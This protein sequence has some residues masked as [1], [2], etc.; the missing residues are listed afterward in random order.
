MLLSSDARADAV[1]DSD[2]VRDAEAQLDS[3]AQPEDTSETVGCND[4]DSVT[5]EEMLAVVV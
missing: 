4:A 5:V 2:T 1:V 3:D